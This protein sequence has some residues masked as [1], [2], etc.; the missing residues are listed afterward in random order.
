[1]KGVLC[2]KKGTGDSDL[3]GPFFV[4]VRGAFALLTSPWEGG[5]SFINLTPVPPSLLKERGEDTKP[6]STRGKLPDF[7]SVASVIVKK[8]V[9]AKRTSSEP[10][11]CAVTAQYKQ[12]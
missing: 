12:V 5:G 7:Y 4:F 9:S 11:F 1:L 2:Y 10:P 3:P 6:L 8:R